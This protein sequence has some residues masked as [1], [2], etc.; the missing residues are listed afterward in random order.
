ML[1]STDEQL[2]E[3]FARPNWGVRTYE[4]LDAVAILMSIEM[5]LPLRDLYA[6]LRFE[7][8]G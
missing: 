1:I 4:G 7:A 6:D 8:L 5:E 2:V 3:V